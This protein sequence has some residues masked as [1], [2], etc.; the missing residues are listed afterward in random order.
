MKFRA[1]LIAAGVVVFGAALV[2]SASAQGDTTN[3]ATNAAHSFAVQA[4]G[5]VCNVVVNNPHRS[6]GASDSRILFKTVVTCTSTYPSVSVNVKGS[7]QEGPL[8]GPKFVATTSNET[9]VIASGKSAT[10]YTPIASGKQVYAAG[11]YTGYVVAE[12]TAPV[13]G[14]IGDANSQTVLI[15]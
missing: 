6:S 13:P 7:L 10:Y 11:T 1:G 4:G 9:Q 2:P 12:I 8:I 3:D 15:K 5:A 14:N